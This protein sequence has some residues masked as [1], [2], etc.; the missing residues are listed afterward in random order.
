M[1]PPSIGPRRLP[2]CA[3][4]LFLAAPGACAGGPGGS[5]EDGHPE[6]VLL[7]AA[8]EGAAPTTP[9]PTCSGTLIGSSTV[10]TSA[11]CAALCPPATRRS[12]WV[13]GTPY[14]VSGFEVQEADGPGESDL[15]L[16]RL[17][18]EIPREVARPVALAMSPPVRGERLLLVGYGFAPDDDERQPETAVKRVAET[19][20]T[21]TYVRTLDLATGH[22]GDRACVGDAGRPALRRDAGAFEVLGV[23]SRGG[24]SAVP[25]DGGVETSVP[26]HYAWIVSNAGGDVPCVPH[27]S[28]TRLV[29]CAGDEA[30][31]ENCADA[32]RICGEI[33]PDA[34]ACVAPEPDHGIC[35]DLCASA[36]D[37]RC[38]DGGPGSDSSACEYGADC[39]DCGP[40]PV[41]PTIRNVATGRCLEIHDVSRED[42]ARAVDSD[43]HGGENQRWALT[44]GELRNQLSGLCL[45][46]FAFSDGAGSAVGQWR[47]HGGQTQRW[48]LVPDG[49]GRFQI[50]SRHEDLCLEVFGSSPEGVA[51]VGQRACQ[52]ADSQLWSLD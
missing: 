10:L 23:A 39:A 13:D 31:E 24:E 21:D 52:A 17:A 34:H 7:D 42:G 44:A 5:E 11:G 19:L 8:C 9:R 46:L 30:F 12:V 22:A 15:A 51:A 2:P 40:R 50:R 1:A 28:G 29:T 26:D 4:L 43:C 35:L 32:G 14:E 45:D 33:G 27:C 41:Y 6:V 36:G 49:T 37:G 38:D 16:A 48:S 3:L 18:E 20:V 25:C 47:C